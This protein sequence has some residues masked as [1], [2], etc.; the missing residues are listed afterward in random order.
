MVLLG[1]WLGVKARIATT[2]ANA[3]LAEAYGYNSSASAINAIFMIMNVFGINALRAARPALSIPAVQYTIF[4]LIGYI[5]GPAEPTEQRS[6]KFVKEL[7]YSFATGQAI[8]TAVSLLIIPVS[9]RKVFFGEATG[10][11]QSAR[12]LLKAQLAFV[13]A[14]EHSELCDPS[15]PRKGSNSEAEIKKVKITLINPRRRKD[16]CIPRKRQP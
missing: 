4:I 14:L 10:F 13:E 12:G 16:C 8:S 5:Y 3:T 15:V 2:P 7:L 11:L 6:I 9:S 1:Q